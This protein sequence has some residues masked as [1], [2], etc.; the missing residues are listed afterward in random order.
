MDPIA[1]T[2][3]LP[4]PVNPEWLTHLLAGCE[5]TIAKFL[6]HGFKN[7]FSIHFEGTHLS[8]D[9]NNLISATENP[10][11]VDAKIAKELKAHRL[12]G[13]F[14][15]P[16]LTPFRVIPKKNFGEFRLIGSLSASVDEAL[17]KN[18]DKYT[19]LTPYITQRTHD[20]LM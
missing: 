1:P 17:C 14:H 5:P 15:N 3:S 6:F 9:S 16:P 4:T 8:S 7:G 2:L 20:P 10:S 19:G 13:P 11:V 18:R 12:A